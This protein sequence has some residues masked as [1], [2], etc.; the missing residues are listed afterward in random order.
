MSSFRVYLAIFILKL[1]HKHQVD[2][3]PTCI[4]IDTNIL[5]RP[6][7]DSSVTS[8]QSSSSTLLRNLRMLDHQRLP[9]VPGLVVESLP[10]SYVDLT[11]TSPPPL[12]DLDD[13]VLQ[14]ALIE[15]IVERLLAPCS[16]E[17]LNEL[18]RQMVVPFE[19]RRLRLEQ[20]DHHSKFLDDEP[21]ETVPDSSTAV[22]ERRSDPDGVRFCRTCRDGQW[23][24]VF[25]DQ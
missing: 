24:L 2:S 14:N 18:E 21:R 11:Q 23:S 1:I 10:L 16:L 25:H 8:N 19:F 15:P 17:S 5:Q 4:I 20:P 3:V 12:I 7:A 13:S 9:S 22:Y 6:E